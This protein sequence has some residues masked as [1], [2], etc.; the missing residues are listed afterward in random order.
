MIGLG[1]G[2]FQSVTQEPFSFGNALQFDGVNDFV[3][4]T[5]Y[6]LGGSGVPF[7]ISAWVKYSSTT[8]TNGKLLFGNSSTAAEFIDVVST[9][10]IRVRMNGTVYSFTTPAITTN[11]F[12]LAITKDASNFLRVYING[13]IS[14][15]LPIDVGV[16]T[17]SNINNIGT[18]AG[19]VTDAL[20]FDQTA[21]WNNYALSGAE[22]STLWNGGS[23]NFITEVGG[24]PFLIYEFNESSGLTA[25]NTGSGAG[26]YTGTLN[27]FT[28]P[29][30]WVA[31]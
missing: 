23:G 8:I 7:S 22:V 6:T 11:W 3:S 30:C 29:D 21:I 2:N 26:T 15:T 4:H 20:T 13:T 18:R 19:T 5:A 9:T 24:T 28:S 1:F 14:V 27:N 31:H 17:L 12:H 16:R 25:P 10:S